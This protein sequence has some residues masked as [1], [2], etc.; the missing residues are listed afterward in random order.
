[1]ILVPLEPERSVLHLC[2]RKLQRQCEAGLGGAPWRAVA[3][4]LERCAV[5][6]EGDLETE[7]SRGG[8]VVPKQK[9]HKGAAKRF[10]VT[11]TGKVMRNHSMKSH[12]LT[13]KSAKRKRH[14]RHKTEVSKA[15]AN[16]IKSLIHS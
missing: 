8:R 3:S 11:G 14:L 7:T 1:M 2:P 6:Q 15:F 16:A 12:I 9:T 4:G 13:K 10:K 5:A